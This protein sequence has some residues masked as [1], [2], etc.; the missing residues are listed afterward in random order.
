SFTFQY[1]PAEARL[2]D[3]ANWEPQD[4]A[5]GKKPLF[6]GNRDPQRISVQELYLDNTMTDRSLKTDLDDLRTLMDE[7]DG[8]GTPPALL[9]IWGD[10]KER[11]VL[12]ELCVE[13]VMF[14]SEG[15]CTRAKISIQLLELQPEGEGTTVRTPTYTEDVDPG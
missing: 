1:F 9:A 4:L 12:E 3:R 2:E 13:E 8:K 11:C 15:E 6:Y 14:N 5:G 7:V 10:H